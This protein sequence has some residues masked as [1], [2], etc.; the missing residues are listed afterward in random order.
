MTGRIATSPHHWAIAPC[1]P[2]RGARGNGIACGCYHHLN[3]NDLAE[4]GRRMTTRALRSAWK[5]WRDLTDPLD[6][7]SDARP[8][9]RALHARLFRLSAAHLLKARHLDAV[10]Q[11]L[12]DAL[13]PWLSAAA[14]AAGLRRLRETFAAC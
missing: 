2:V 11:A 14:P 5:R 9:V 10:R 7:S 6:L 13:D 1:L 8:D 4:E 12:L 3:R